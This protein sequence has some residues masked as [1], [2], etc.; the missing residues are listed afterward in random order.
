MGKSVKYQ[1]LTN[2][3]KNLLT[4]VNLRLISL[5]RQIMVEHGKELACGYIYELQD[6][7]G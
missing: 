3:H 7:E 4:D 2:F 6:P 5:F 1:L